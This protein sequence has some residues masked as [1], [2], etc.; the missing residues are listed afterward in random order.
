M[1][2]LSEG[3]HRYSKLYHFE[4]YGITDSDYYI[5]KTAKNETEGGVDF[6][7]PSKQ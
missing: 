2:V 7:L 3:L 6:L 5:V 1:S 4:S